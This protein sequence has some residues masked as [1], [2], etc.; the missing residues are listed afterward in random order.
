[1]LLVHL[2]YN[3]VQF[4][5]F[6]GRLLGEY[7]RFAAGGFIFVSG[8]SIGVIFL[9]RAM[10]ERKR[11]K[12]CRTLWRRSAYILGVNYLS[13]MILVMIALFIDIFR[14]LP[15]EYTD[16]LVVLRRI[17]LLRE[18]GDLL[19]FYVM[20]IAVS[21][22]LMQAVRRRWGWL[23]VLVGSVALFTWGLWHPWA[24][25]PAQHDKFPPVLWQM[26][27]VTGFVFGWAWPRYNQ[28][29]ARTRGIIAIVAWTMVAVLFVMEYSYQWG[30]PGLG[31][32]I[33]F[34]K[35]PL[36]TAEAVRYLS[37]MAAIIATTDLIWT[38][39]SDFSAVAFVQTLGRKS[40]PVY[41]LHLWLV[42]AIGALAVKWSWMGPWQIT[43]AVA[44]LLILWLFALSLDI[45]KRPTVIGPL[46]AGALPR[47]FGQSTAPIAR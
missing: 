36:S 10:D 4:G 40:L 28:I 13:A 47:L 43:M 18:G 21:P 7:T 9:P 17:F 11:V 33:A 27:F 8:L 1:M 2:Y 19:P 6:L 14:N 37:V 34:V 22:L 26:I 23:Y 42:E 24:L 15:L 41:V 45:W 35:V 46:G 3:N 20:M 12:T 29:T 31:L 30:M 16:P 39:I 32:G 25:A 44:S 5:A 38:K